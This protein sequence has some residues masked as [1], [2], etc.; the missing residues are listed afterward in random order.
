MPMNLVCT[1]TF[2]DF[3]FGKVYE[4]TKEK[5][6]R[7]S[8][9]MFWKVI[10]GLYRE[11]VLQKVKINDRY[12]YSCLMLFFKVSDDQKKLHAKITILEFKNWL[13]KKKQ[14]S[15]SVLKNTRGFNWNQKGKKLHY[16][17]ITNLQESFVSFSL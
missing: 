6:C 7:L 2:P 1:Q 11:G 4:Q 16:T 14:N 15:D 12:K 9:F 5:W 3:I 13:D 10:H 17:I 8:C